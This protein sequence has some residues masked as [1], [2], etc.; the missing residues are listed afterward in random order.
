MPEAAEEPLMRPE[1]HRSQLRVQP[2]CPDHQVKAPSVAAREDDI[3]PVRVL[4]E[5]GDPVAEDVLEPSR[6]AS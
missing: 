6:V 2:V 1:D 4:G 5:L 3:D